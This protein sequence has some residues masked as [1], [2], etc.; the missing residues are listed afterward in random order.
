MLLHLCLMGLNPS[1]VTAERP[2]IRVAG[3]R[4]PGFVLTRPEDHDSKYKITDSGV[5]RRS[6]HDEYKSNIDRLHEQYN[7]STMILARSVIEKV[8]PQTTVNRST[9]SI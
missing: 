7:I 4:P 5:P 1:G 3:F 9:E 8:G 2:M 6:Y